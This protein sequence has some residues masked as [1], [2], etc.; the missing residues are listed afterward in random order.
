M[1]ATA[2]RTVLLACGC[3][4]QGPPGAVGTRDDVCGLPDCHGTAVPYRRPNP[5]AR[6][7]ENR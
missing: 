3:H 4:D 7:E 5:P 1:N 2:T 6:T